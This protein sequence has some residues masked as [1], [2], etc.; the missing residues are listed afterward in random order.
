MTRFLLFLLVLVVLRLQPAGGSSG[1]GGVSKTGRMKSVEE[2]RP[3]V[4]TIRS[5][6]RQHLYN[7]AAVYLYKRGR[8]D[9]YRCV[10]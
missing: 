6:N 4:T 5:L 8:K 10:N 3:S 7:S 1:A 9:I 2:E